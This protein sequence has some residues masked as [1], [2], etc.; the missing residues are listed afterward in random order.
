MKL[1]QDR[2]AMQGNQKNM[3]EYV[4]DIFG[5]DIFVPL[6]EGVIDDEHQCRTPEDMDLKDLVHDIKR[7]LPN[8]KAMAMQPE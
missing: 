7:N 6:P 3:Y 8:S 4:A 2:F 5:K 1:I